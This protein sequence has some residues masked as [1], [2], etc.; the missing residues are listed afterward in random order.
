M[1]DEFFVY[2]LYSSSIDTFY[3]GQTN[4]LSERLKQ[5]KNKLVGRAFT[6]RATDWEIYHSISCS[7]RN[8]AILI[9]R[10]LKR[11]RRRKYLEDLKKY[12]E[13]A[14]S[15]LKKYPNDEFQ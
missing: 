9:E 7:T 11:A 3:I 13:I 12:P 15:L 6:K 14:L 4:N 8:Q 2:I 1:V 5:H 10:H